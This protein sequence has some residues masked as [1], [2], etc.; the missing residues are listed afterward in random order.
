M[1]VFF[2]VKG[3]G[4]AING[5]R[6]DSTVDC[7]D[8]GKARVHLKV[9]NYNDDAKRAYDSLAKK[10]GRRLFLVSWLRVLLMLSLI[11]LSILMISSLLFRCCY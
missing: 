4:T 8:L 2:G 10:V 5:Q 9:P 7:C 11:V 1:R 3:K 6:V